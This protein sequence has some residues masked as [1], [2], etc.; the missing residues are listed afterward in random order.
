VALLALVIAGTRAAAQEPPKAALRLG[1]TPWAPFTDVPGKAR[2]AIDLV[3]AALQRIGVSVETDIVP[4]GSLT[5]ALDAGR[6]HGSP[7][8]W[9]D[10]ER[11]KRLLYSKPYLEN[12][13]VLVARAGSDVS[14]AAFPALAGK[15]VALVA[16]YAYGDETKAAGGPTYVT[17][18]TVE[19]SL[20]MVLAGAADYTLM[21]E[22]VVQYLLANYPEESKRLAIGS[23]PLVVRT[24]HF[25]LRRDLP[26][27]ESVVGR[28]D[29]E[30]ERMIAD[31]SYHQILRLGWIQADA[32]GDGRTEWVP[33]SDQVGQAP[34][35]R[36]YELVTV[37]AGSASPKPPGS[38]RFYV[39]GAV[40]EG[41][42]SV[43]ERYKAIDQYRSPRGTQMAPLFSFKW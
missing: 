23:A 22:L 20:E 18:A 27:A 17:A 16:G 15:R 31:R 5:P 35:V 39:G 4:E 37:T 12:Q 42:A 30:L 38:L 33:A 43:P 26:Y 1:S 34:P 10:A 32:D 25:A 11:E 21:D 3:H 28:F 14:A 29:A 6:F 7:A 13:L 41:W 36:R 24:L 19:A 40:Y 8:L 9:R 2:F